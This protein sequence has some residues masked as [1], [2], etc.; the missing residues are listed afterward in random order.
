M[1]CDWHRNGYVYEHLLLMHTVYQVSVCSLLH[2]Y[3]FCSLSLCQR[4]RSTERR[5]APTTYAVFSAS[6]D[7]LSGNPQL[8]IAH[9]CLAIILQD[10]RHLGI[11]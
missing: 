5:T 2:N 9:K 8:H 4:I 6:F 10:D 7:N 1:S 3:L 11:F